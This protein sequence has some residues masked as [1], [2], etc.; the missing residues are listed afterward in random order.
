MAA[1]VSEGLE[2]LDDPVD[3]MQWLDYQWY[4]PGDLLVK[5]D[6]ASMA[7]SLEA[8]SPFLDHRVIEFCAALPSTVKTDGRARKI[9]LREAF[10]GLLPDA[11]LGPSEARVQYPSARL[12]AGSVSGAGAGTSG[13][14]AAEVSK[15]FSISPPSGAC[16]KPTSAADA[17]MPTVCGPSCYLR[18]GIG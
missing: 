3:L 17:I 8:R 13:G 12:V 15:N 11:I 5:M 6:I 16:S 14:A 9:V 18:S 10:R 7:C 1:L 4:L 2:H